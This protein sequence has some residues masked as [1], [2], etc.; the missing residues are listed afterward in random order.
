MRI[1]G[2]ALVHLFIPPLPPD[3]VVTLNR[4][5][6][7]HFAQYNIQHCLGWEG[8]GR[9]LYDHDQLHCQETKTTEI[10]VKE[11]ESK[12]I[13]HFNQNVVSN[14]KGSFVPLR[15]HRSVANATDGSLHA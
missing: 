7:T 2:Q 9:Q 12:S 10:T 11:N 1:L 14:R 4:L 5:I 3:N 13:K 15:Y 6:F 8:E